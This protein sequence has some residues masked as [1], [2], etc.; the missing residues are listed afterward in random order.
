MLHLVPGVDRVH[1]PSHKATADR[2]SGFQGLTSNLKLPNL[3]LFLIPI[4]GIILLTGL[5]AVLAA[6]VYR[7]GRS[8]DPGKTHLIRFPF[9]LFTTFGTVNAYGSGGAHFGILE[10]A[11]L[12]IVPLSAAWFRH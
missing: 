5:P 7:F 1:P 10:I 12:D 6:K 8:A 4:V 3:K 2:G 9:N 11:H